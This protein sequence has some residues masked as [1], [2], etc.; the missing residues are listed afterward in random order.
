M[1]LASLISGVKHKYHYRRDI[2]IVS[3]LQ[4]YQAVRLIVIMVFKSSELS[5]FIA[6]NR[7]DRSPVLN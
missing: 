1:V 4:G 3:I 6:I 5:R 2:G 7:S